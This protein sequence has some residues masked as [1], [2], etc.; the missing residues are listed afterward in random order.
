[1]HPVAGRIYLGKYET[2]RLL[3]EGGMGSVSL[4]RSLDGDEPVVVKVMHEH[5]ANE[6][7]FRERFDREISLMAAFQHPHAI[8]FIEAGTDPACPCLVME[9]APGVTLDKLLAKNGPFSPMRIR[10][11]L[12]QFCDVLQ[13]A[14]DASIIHRDLKPANLMVLDPDTPFEKLKVMD[15]GLAE[16]AGPPPAG[17]PRQHAVG[18]PGYMSPEQVAGGHVDHRGDIYSVGAI[19]YQL[20]S[21]SLPFSGNSAMEIL[22]AQA[23]EPAPTFA[24]LGLADKV[25]PPVEA[26]ILSCLATE[27]AERPQSARELGE[28]YEAALVEAFSSPSGLR[29]VPA[30]PAGTPSITPPVNE[31]TP[32][33]NAFV[34]TLEASMPE[35]SVAYKVKAFVEEFHGKL[36]ETKPGVIRFRF[37]APSKESKSL[38][39]LIGL[40]RRVGAI[41]VEM[42]I[43]HRDPANDNHLF[44]TLLFRPEGGRQAPDFP[45]WRA[46]CNLILQGLKRY[47]K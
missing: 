37:R 47:L 1:M 14:H 42:R 38:L 24:A 29:F 2:V 4:A 23:T 16:M 36:L 22:M 27:P 3:G 11:I 39:S 28:A 41:E 25:P 32:D 45:A 12:S 35:A 10:R 9:F 34:E 6:P 18:T 46:R 33:P 15:F 7:A 31:P 44:I 20:L 26:V 17:A 30:P 13:A 21:G 43:A 5:I 40:R 8:R 19:L